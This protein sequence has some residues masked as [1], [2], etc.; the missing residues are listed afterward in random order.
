MAL[1]LSLA[2]HGAAG[3]T[4]GSRHLVQVDDQYV[5]LDCGLFQGRRKETYERNLSFGF[6]PRSI[7]SVILSHAHIDHSGNL[8]NLV[9]QGFAGPIWATPATTDLCGIMLRDSAHI[10]EK[11]AEWV[12]KR[13]GRNG[14]GGRG[15]RE[16]NGDAPVQP[17]YTTEDAEAAIELFKSVVYHT[18]FDVLPEKMSARFFDAGHILG[19]SGVVM[20]I[21]RHDR[22]YRL[23]YSG[24]IGRKD[25]PILRDPEIPHNVD[26]LIM[27]STYG[28]RTHDDIHD[29]KE[30]LRATV[31]RVAARGGK[32]V[33]PSFSV[34]RTQEIVY[35]LNELTNEGKLPPI[36]V[37]VD[38]PL[39][40]NATEVF[41]AHPECFRR[42]NAGTPETGPGSLRLLPPDLHSRRGRKQ[43]P[44]Q[45]DD[46]GDHHLGLG[47]VRGRAHPAPSAQLD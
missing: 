29:A 39:A 13:H 10:Q 36:P 22:A 32:I 12:N 21:Q 26:W 28:A 2:F 40:V 14:R 23:A 35:F 42:R 31:A 16:N 3:S 6:P 43:E 7:H 20:D 9:K 45:P 15:A 5:L 1:N 34:E 24:D 25:L 30:E 8:P 47:D 46:A 17:I 4:T 18:P 41:R 33:I 19:S 44:Q 27:E 37:Y 38:S 11:D